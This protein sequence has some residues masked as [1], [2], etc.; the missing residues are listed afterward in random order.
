M[1][2]LAV[3][4]TLW[5]RR[6]RG[7]LPDRQRI[8][9]PLVLVS[10][11]AEDCI[12]G[13]DIVLVCVS[14]ADVPALLRRIA[15]HLSE[16]VVVGGIPGFG[17]F[18]IAAAQIVPHAA[19]IF[20]TQRI[21]FVVRGFLPG[22]HVT[23]GGIRRQ[24]FVG[25]MPAVRAKPVS[26]LVQELLG[27]R[28]VPVSHYVNIELSPSNSVVNPARLFSLFG[29]ARRNPDLKTEF[30]VDWD[31]KSSRGDNHCLPLCL[32]KTTR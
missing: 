30:F 32:R 1:R 29:T 27:V 17:G 11:S 28:T 6:L 10:Q 12:A 7:I 18:G 20:G 16:R 5:S 24:T 3:N 19:C 8:A 15:P 14:H 4:G 31:I 9:A 26:E 25:T 23:I 21:P 2:V 22:R 13:S